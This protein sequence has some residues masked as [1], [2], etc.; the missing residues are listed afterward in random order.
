MS[1]NQGRVE[2]RQRPR[3]LRW[4]DILSVDTP[5]DRIALAV[6]ESQ[7]DAMLRLVPITVVVQIVAAAI[8]VVG[9]RG[10][11]ENFELGLWFGA[12]LLLCFARG[13]RAWRLR[14]DADYADEHPASLSGICVVVAILAFFWVIPPIA[15]FEVASPSEKVFICILMTA[16]LS[17]GSMTL[18]SLPQTALLYIGILTIGAAALAIKVDSP[19]MFGLVLAYSTILATNVLSTARRFFTHSRDRIELREQG[20]II[21]LLREFEASGSGGLWELDARLNFTK[22]SN[23]LLFAI[24]LD[25]GQVVGRHYTNL[26]DPDGQ[27]ARHSSGMRSLYNDL[28]RGTTFRDR[29]IPSADRK[30][31][32]S[33]SGKPILDERGDLAGWRGVASDITESRLSG[34]DSVRAARTDPLTG[35]ANRLLVRELLEQ[36]ALGHWNEEGHCALLLVDLDR[37]KLV[38]DTLGHAIGDQLLV[39]VGRRLELAVGTDGRVGRIGGDEFAIIWTSATDRENLSRLAD[40]IVGRLAASFSIGAATLRIGAT[41]G[42]AIGPNDGAREEQLMRSADLALYRAKEAGRGGYAFFERYMFDEAEDHRLL[43]QDVREALGSDGLTLAYQPIVA[44]DSSAVVAHEALLRWRHPRRGDI[45][46]DQFIPIIEDAGLIHQIGDWVIREA[47]MEASRWPGQL[48]VAVNISAAQLSGAG[49]ART[50][51]GALAASRLEPSRLE[52]EVTESVFLGDDAAT[53]AS[54]E[55]LRALGVRLVLDDFG[56]GYSSFGYLSRAQFAKIKI[57]QSFVRGAAEGAKDCMAIVHA[58]LALARGLGVETTAEGVETAAQ[59][60]VMRSL[61]CDLLQGF[62]F[63]RPVAP[64]LLDLEPAAQSRRAG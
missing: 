54:L 59:A 47:C 7:I 33:L 38:N 31:W 41:I 24:G 50:V 53:L 19:V 30:R 27:I 1:G 2:R 18:I 15:W 58:I 35:L 60:D 28:E 17:A 11:V 16:L 10:S 40:I 61:G 46:P 64:A 23:E 56:K 63:G 43:E 13:V 22:I 32:W 12:V 62:H 57:D 29:A 25:E 14:H 26:L 21:K 48:R 44:A 39:E 42:I 52:L 9:L 45:P 8:M 5:S 20:E 37:F 51:L 6:R 4:R 55:R 36:A 49:L 34:S 3:H